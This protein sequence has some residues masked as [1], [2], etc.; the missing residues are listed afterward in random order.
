M[1]AAGSE[2]PQTFLLAHVSMLLQEVTNSNIR[3]Q[4]ACTV[5]TL[6]ACARTDMC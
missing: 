1:C 3:V 6:P 2:W 5:N 4:S